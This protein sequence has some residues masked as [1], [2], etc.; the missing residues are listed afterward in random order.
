VGRVCSTNGNGRNAY[1]ILVRKLEGRRPLR[2]P[3]SRWVDNIKKDLRKIGWHRLDRFGSVYGPV[4][5]SCEHGNE[6]SGSIYCWE[7][8]E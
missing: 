6:P 2:R 7:V 8:L 3:R 5:G 1:R 4:N